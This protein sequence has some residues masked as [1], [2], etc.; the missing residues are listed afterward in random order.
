[1]FDN[2]SLIGTKPPAIVLQTRRGADI[3][4]SQSLPPDEPSIRKDHHLASQHP[5]WELRRQAYG[6]CNC[7]GV[8]WGN[9]RTAIYEQTE[10]ELILKDD[11]YRRFSHTQ[12]DP[13]S[14]GDLV[15]YRMQNSDKFLHVGMIIKLVEGLS[16]PSPF[17]ISKWNDC[18]REVVH[19]LH[20]VPQ[21][22][23][24]FGYQVEYWTDRDP[25]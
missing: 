20:D 13:L 1:M 14:P 8:V 10:W 15:L 24:S 16:E 18:S 3:N 5:Y 25:I 19:Q 6:L 23:R 11:G 12:R 7:A 9:R 17:L 2:I 4:N 22:Y 21:Q